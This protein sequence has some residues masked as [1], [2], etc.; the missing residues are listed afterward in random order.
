M[1]TYII[2]NKRGI[3]DSK[4]FLKICRKSI[5][6]EIA[7]LVDEHNI[8]AN[9]VFGAEYT[10]PTSGVIQKMNFKTKNTVILPTTDIRVYVITAMKKL[11]VEMEEFYAKG[12]GWTLHKIIHLELRINRYV[13]LR[14]SSYMELPKKI[15]AKKTVVNIMNNDQ[16]CFVWSI[17]AALHPVDRQSKPER[18]HHYQPLKYDLDVHLDGITFL[19]SLDHVKLFEKRSGIS[20]NV[21]SYDEKLVV[22]PFY[23]TREEKDT[24]VDL[25]YIR[26]QTNS[27]YCLIK[28]LSRLVRS[29]ITKHT[30]KTWLC[31]CCLMH[32]GTED[33]LNKHK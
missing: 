28:D 13:P 25:L 18:I 5:T 19:V 30:T 29:Q 8:K 22:Y 17:L 27:H 14:G 21:Y 32:Y 20:I 15:S 9:L 10:K 23:I 12:S 24:H 26:D 31:K 11:F 3:K 2:Q 4:R 7:Q 33:L 1:L 16:K 6:R